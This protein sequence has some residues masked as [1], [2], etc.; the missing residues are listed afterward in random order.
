[1]DSQFL[2]QED[3][4]A[5][6]GYRRKTKQTRQLIQMGIPH[7]LN[8]SGIPKVLKCSLVSRSEIQTQSRPAWRPKFK[9]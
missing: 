7:I 1:M 2:N 8:K 3:V 6:T 5:L 9:I 4:V